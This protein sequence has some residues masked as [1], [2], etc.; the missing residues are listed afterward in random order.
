MQLRVAEEV[1]HIS[2]YQA[3]LMERDAS[4]QADVG[5]RKEDQQIMMMEWRK[6][7]EV[8]K[9]LQAVHEPYSSA[10]NYQAEL[11]VRTIEM[12]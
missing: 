7:E 10:P 3:A 1:E 8:T 11:N 6:L 2:S 12:E 9:G 4:L 5:K